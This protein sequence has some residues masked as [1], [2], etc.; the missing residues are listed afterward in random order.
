MSYKNTRR[1]ILQPILLS[2]I[3]IV[4]IF[5]GYAILPG[6]LGSNKSLVIYPQTNKI[7]AILNLIE[8]EYVDTVDTEKMQEAIIPELLK[9]TRSSYSLYPFK[10]FK[11]CK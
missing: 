3:L 5:I 8:E 11:K 6:K 7:D 10:R 1:Q 9:K 4:G 2:L